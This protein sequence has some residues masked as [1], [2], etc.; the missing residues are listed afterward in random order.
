MTALAAP[1]DA[2]PVDDADAVRLRFPVAC[3][4]DTPVA[5]AALPAA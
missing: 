1:T 5:E 3:V 2:E 4:V